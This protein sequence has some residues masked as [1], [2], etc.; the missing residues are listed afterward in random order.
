MVVPMSW[1]FGICCNCLV[2]LLQLVV[3]ARSDGFFK[4]HSRLTK[5]LF[6]KYEKALLPANS[7]DVVSAKIGLSFMDFH[8]IDKEESITLNAWM[9]MEWVD[10][11]LSWD[12]SE[13][14][15]LT[16]LRVNY[17][18]I[19][20]P[21]VVLY[22]AYLPQSMNP[23]FEETMVQ[24]TS[25][26]LVFYPSHV[27]LKAACPMDLRNFPYDTQSCRFKF[28][29]WIYNGFQLNITK[30]SQVVDLSNYRLNQ[31]WELTNTTTT[32]NVI[33]Y[34]CCPESYPDITFNLTIKRRPEQLSMMYVCPAF[35]L[36]L[37][38]P[39]VFLQPY[40]SGDK[41]MLAVGIQLCVLSVVY[42]LQ[43]YINADRTAS[44]LLVKYYGLIFVCAT[45]ALITSTVVNAVIGGCVRGPP[46]S[47]Y[48]IFTCCSLCLCAGGEAPVSKS[49]SVVRDEMSEGYFNKRSE[50]SP[51][52]T[53][54]AKWTV[55]ATV[56]D[57]INFVVF[58]ALIGY[59]MAA[60]FVE[61]AKV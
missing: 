17:K 43:D 30:R 33:Y 20:R 55:I 53:A 16:T 22:N 15:G 48:K 8:V 7:T 13:Y 3:V 59:G 21:D 24:I 35:V 58:V 2:V 44:P 39:L 28:G 60:Y 34:S 5:T 51:P 27:T 52:K 19:W 1:S 31:R 9:D 56:I 54:R 46:D 50:G 10:F 49:E 14:N 47:L 61:M 41:T 12:P 11:R 29:S 38:V 18:N 6:S 23:T 25:D 32:T 45:A 57:R 4:D 40:G 37:L 42:S 26:G 36:A